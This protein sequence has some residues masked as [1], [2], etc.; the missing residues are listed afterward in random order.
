MFWHLSVVVC[1]TR[2][3]FL[4][5]EAC[6]AALTMAISAD[7]VLGSCCK[8]AGLPHAGLGKDSQCS[9]LLSVL[10]GCPRHVFMV[11]QGRCMLTFAK[12]PD[13]VNPGLCC[14]IHIHIE[15]SCWW[16]CRVGAC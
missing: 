5:I 1:G 7:G 3:E 4:F 10:T 13:A 11:L 16:L 15:E 2:A 8:P 12:M 9:M 6:I 14:P